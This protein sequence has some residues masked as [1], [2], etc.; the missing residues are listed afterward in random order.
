MY[1]TR[2]KKTG[3]AF[4]KH[5]REHKYKYY[6]CDCQHVTNRQEHLQVD[7]WK[8]QSCD[9]C[10]EIV[11]LTR[12]PIHTLY[13]HKKKEGISC[14]ECEDKK[15]FT[16]HLKFK[17]HMD[18][19]LLQRSS[20]G[21]EN[22]VFKSFQ[23]K[24]H[25]MQVVHIKEKFGCHKKGCYFLCITQEEMDHH[26]SLRHSST[27]ICDICGK[28]WDTATSL[29]QHKENHHAPKH[30]C[31]LCPSMLSASRLKIHIAKVHKGRDGGICNICGVKV[32]YLPLHMNQA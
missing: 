16:D 4:F 13:K 25:H 21:C 15:V 27:S 23:H 29:K 26:I 19:H 3:Q 11:P 28:S 9:R 7:H 1:T 18:E 10:N 5:L 12:L 31:P 22:I 32:N 20:C 30:Q 14:N 24:R 6:S 2:E 17:L 8:W